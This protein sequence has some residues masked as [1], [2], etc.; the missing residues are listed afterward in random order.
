[1]SRLPPEEQDLH[2]YVDGQLD[3]EQRKWVEHY[4]QKHPEAASQVAKWQADAQKLRVSLNEFVP[5][6]APRTTDLQ[7]VR[8]RMR[9]TRQWQLSMAFS[10]LFCV[11]IGG[12]AGWQLHA[13]Q[14]QSQILPMEDAVQADRLISDGNV[15]ALDVVASDQGQMNGWM[16]RYFINGALPPN[17]QNYGFN[18]IGGRLM[19]TEQG[20]AALVV[21]QDARGMRVTYYIRPTG[22]IQ[23]G[24]GE[25]KT[26]NLMAQYWS[27][28]RYNYAVISPANNH[29]TATLQQA[30]AH[31][32][33][34]VQ[35]I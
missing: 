29:Q 17:L 12:I 26:D 31:F 5:H 11:G 10:L 2:A 35:S 14:V 13:S 4:L 33:G 6:T 18:I 28:Q 15:K 30:I 24:K 7:Q 25:R 27:D 8:Q 34:D 20:P 3:D 16:S 32:T 9:K 23:I 1:M 22:R 21:Y 19:V